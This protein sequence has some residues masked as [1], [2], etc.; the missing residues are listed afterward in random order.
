MTIFDHSR[1]DVGMM[2]MIIVLLRVSRNVE[3][4]YDSYDWL[5]V[6]GCHFLA[7]SHE[8][9]VAIIIPIDDSSYFS[10]GWPNHQPDMDIPT[11][12]IQLR[13]VSWNIH[14]DLASY[15][16]FGQVSW[17]GY[18]RNHPTMRPTLGFLM[19]FTQNLEGH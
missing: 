12:N 11:M 9:W 10:E 2:E 13:I 16:Y 4:I 14:M 8:Y 7:F 17:P 1:D 15:G 6:T 19:I 5:V 18:R 3:M